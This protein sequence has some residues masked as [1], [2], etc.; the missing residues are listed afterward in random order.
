M[1]FPPAA[2]ASRFEWEET[3][4]EIAFSFTVE[5]AMFVSPSILSRRTHAA[6]TDWSLRLFH[7]PPPGILSSA[8][9]LKSPTNGDTRPDSASTE[10]RKL[11]APS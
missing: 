5:E 1:R 11:G 8:S 6:I 10:R 9:F 3:S 7:P 4:S 2:F